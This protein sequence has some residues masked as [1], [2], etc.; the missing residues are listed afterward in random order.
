MNV[1]VMASAEMLREADA[2]LGSAST[3]KMKPFPTIVRK[4]RSF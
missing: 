1:G 4:N 2:A 3:E